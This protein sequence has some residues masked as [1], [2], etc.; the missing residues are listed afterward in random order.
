MIK[1]NDSISN[2]IEKVMTV[3]IHSIQWS[4]NNEADGGISI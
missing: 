3:S 4:V 2:N 1:T